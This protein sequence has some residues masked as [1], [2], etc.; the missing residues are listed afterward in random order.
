MHQKPKCSVQGIDGVISDLFRHPKRVETV[1][2]LRVGHQFMLDSHTCKLAGHVC[3]TTT[4]RYAHLAPDTLKDAVG[5]LDR[6]LER[7]VSC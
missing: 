4:Q 2:P 1:K 7:D 5:Q 6:R 3:I